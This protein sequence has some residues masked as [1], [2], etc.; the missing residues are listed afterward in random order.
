MQ[1]MSRREVLAFFRRYRGAGYHLARA[2]PGVRVLA[3]AAYQEKNCKP[4]GSH[5]AQ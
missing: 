1:H 5:A 2:A 3:A 4:K